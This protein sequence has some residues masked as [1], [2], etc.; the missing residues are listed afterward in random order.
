[1]KRVL[2]IGS[3]G[4]GKSTFARRLGE[5]TGL[6]VIHLDKL[7]W[8]PNWVEPAR[9]DWKKTVENALKGDSWIMDGNYSGTMELRLPACDTVIFLDF[10]RALCAFRVVKRVAFSYGRTRPDMASDCEEQFDWEFV[11]WVWNF[12][13][14]TKPKVE[15]LLK[16]FENE[17]TIIRLQS[18]RE[19]ESF[20]A[21]FF[22]N[23]V[24][25]S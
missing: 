13:T 20:F 15:A 6:E 11:K 14:R 7:Y 19:V 21:K 16:Q 18:K 4:A 17:K 3:S 25:S 8:K 5:K 10:P 9:S 12:P 22:S 24:E 1:M 23:T 2:V